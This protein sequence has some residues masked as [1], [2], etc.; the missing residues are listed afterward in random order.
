MAVL[1]VFFFNWYLRKVMNWLL[2]E[3]SVLTLPEYRVNLTY[4][5]LDINCEDKCMENELLTMRRRLT[6]S[7]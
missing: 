2:A 1:G 5:Q 4:K 6:S 7:L 3:I